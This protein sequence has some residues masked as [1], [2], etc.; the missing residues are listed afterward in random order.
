V[1]V[2][3][4]ISDVSIYKSDFD[5]FRVTK[6]DFNSDFDCFLYSYVLLLNVFVFT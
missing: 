3:L 6:F 1:K 4:I 2:V 5:Y